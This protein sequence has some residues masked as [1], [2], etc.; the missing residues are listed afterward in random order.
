MGWIVI[1]ED[2][3]YIKLVSKSE[4]DGLLPKGSFLTVDNG[5][6]KFILR[7]DKSSQV[8]PYTPSPMIIDMDLS[9]LPQDQKCQNLVY[10]YRIKDMTS[11]IDG[12]I[13]FIRPQSVARRSNQEEVNQAL[14]SEAKGTKVFVATVHAGQNQLL[15]D[16]GGRYITAIIPED[17]FFHQILICGKTGSGKT[18]ATKYLTQYF[19]EELEGAVLAIN[20][21]DVDFLRMDK[22]S[23][24]NSQSILKE[25][26]TLGKQPHGIENY[27]IYYPA[28]RSINNYNNP[29]LDLSLFKPITLSVHDIEPEALTGLLQGISDVGAQSLP[30]IFR[31]WQQRVK[32]EYDTFNSF[33]AYFIDAADHRTFDT[34]NIRGDKLSIPLHTATYNN[35]Q[36]T[37]VRATSFFDNDDAHIIDETDIL[38]RGKMSVIDVGNEGLQFG[39][40]MLRHL[41]RRIVEAKSTQRSNVPVLIVIDEVHNFYKS[42]A[43]QDALGDLDTICRQGRSQEVGVIF[44]SQTPNDIP[45]GL[46]SVINT[47]I[48]FKSDYSNMKISAFGVS[49]NELESL[50]KG[51]AVANIHELSK[52]KILKFPLSLSGVF[53]QRS[54]N[55]E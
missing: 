47:K 54:T 30:D 42:D 48:F 40:I 22:P 45:R 6:T 26:T 39:S 16:D 3:G 53:E 18:V 2:N 17:M 34:L 1:G 20:V 15:V 32:G 4:E 14:G 25:W 24:T 5:K 29:G 13:D 44:S 55:G 33:V 7:V 52:L 21:K 12:K 27:V 49:S 28:N 36:R 9:G 19:V 51:F 8:E 50:N 23:D 46:E 10:A 31:Y 43:A 37:L 38:Q 41:L 11:R 35:V